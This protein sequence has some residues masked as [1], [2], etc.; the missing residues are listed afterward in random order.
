MESI[1]QLL[2]LIAAIAGM[3]IV[4]STASLLKIESPFQKETVEGD[5]NYVANSIADHIYKCMEKN[6]RR[7]GAIICSRITVNSEEVIASDDVL[8]AL[9]NKG[10]DESKVKIEESD[11]RGEIIIRY[12]NENIYVKKI[13][14]SVE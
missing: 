13:V 6:A 14:K 10:F 7:R 9:K 3:L 2:F 1:K 12:E 8:S 11:L 5:K 4:I